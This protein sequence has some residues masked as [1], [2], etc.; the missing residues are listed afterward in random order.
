MGYAD[1]IFTA[2]NRGDPIHA[3]EVCFQEADGDLEEKK[4]CCILARQVGIDYENAPEHLKQALSLCPVLL[5]G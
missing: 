2:V 5:E 3:L 4:F 1:A